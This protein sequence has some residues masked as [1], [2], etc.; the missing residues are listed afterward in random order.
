VKG[1]EVGDSSEKKEKRYPVGLAIAFG[2]NLRIQGWD[3]ST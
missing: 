3:T 2:V 1:K